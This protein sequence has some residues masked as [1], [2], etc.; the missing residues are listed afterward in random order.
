MAGSNNSACNAARLVE[1]SMLE[2]VQSITILN[3]LA[4]SIRLSTLQCLCASLSLIGPCQM[5]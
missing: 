4:W 2:Q 5:F 1:H 3:C